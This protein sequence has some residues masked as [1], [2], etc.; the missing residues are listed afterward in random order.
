ME[1]IKSALLID[2][3]NIDNFINHRLLQ[4]HGVTHII[5]FHDSESALSYLKDTHVVYHLILVNI[6]A[7]DKKG[8][9]FIEQFY[10]AGLEKKQGKIY[11]I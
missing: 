7:P 10:K 5:S 2:N 8:V 3:N 4:R 1:A 9:E 6:E 11:A